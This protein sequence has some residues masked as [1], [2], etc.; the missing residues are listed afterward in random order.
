MRAVGYRQLWEYLDGQGSRE[1][2]IRKGIVATRRLAKRQL[3]WMRAEQDE[4]QFD[5]LSPNVAAQVIDTIQAHISEI[6]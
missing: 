1:A 4:R 2:A 5:C 3:T 6:S